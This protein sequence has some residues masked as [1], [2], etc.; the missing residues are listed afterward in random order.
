MPGLRERKKLKTRLAI[1]RAAF[2]LFAERGYED[3]TIEQIAAAADIS[4]RTFYR[5]F[6][7]KE[8]VLI[9]DEQIEPIVRAFAR[10]PRKLSTVAA[11]RHAVAEVFGALSDEEREAATTA[12]RLMYD[13]PEARSLLYSDYARLIDMIAEAMEGRHDAPADPLARRVIAGAIVGVLICA[14][15]DTPMPE[16]SLMAA[17]TILDDRLSGG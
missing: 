15:H 3:T 16:D 5:Y 17:L 12:Q 2:Q 13:V 4:P 11:Y 14:S 6:A 7:G 10:A 8:A 9:N 1:R